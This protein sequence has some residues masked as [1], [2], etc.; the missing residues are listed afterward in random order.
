MGG[1]CPT[2]LPHWR[3]LYELDS[4]RR[5]G[6]CRPLLFLGY[7]SGEYLSLVPA[8]AAGKAEL[9]IRAEG[10]VAVTLLSSSTVPTGQWFHV[11]FTLDG[12]TAKLYIN[13]QPAAT[14]ACAFHPCQL[15]T[16]NIQESAQASYV[17]RGWN[18]DCLAARIDDLRFY[19]TAI[20]PQAIKQA[21][22][23]NGRV[24]TR[25]YE[26]APLTLT[27]ATTQ[28]FDSG[29]VSPEQCTL[30]VDVKA[31]RV[32]DDAMYRP[33][34]DAHSEMKQTPEPGSPGIGIDKGEYVVYL[35]GEGRWQT[36]AACTT[37]TWQNVVLTYTPAEAALYLDGKEAARKPIRQ[38]FAREVTFHVGCSRLP[39][40]SR[41]IGALRNVRIYDKALTKDEVARA[42]TRP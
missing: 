9:T 20:G 16:P 38:D 40:A 26:D 12:T 5:N 27:D 37:G 24:L 35:Q 4:S 17:G 19:N 33:I 31:D 6:P 13:G 25:L 18:G 3:A 39:A 28:T 21:I 34:L 32:D 11:G 41:F 7:K 10:G 42:L 23:E 15:I 2:R 22:R 30:M 14:G 29:I 1:T 8:N 36:G